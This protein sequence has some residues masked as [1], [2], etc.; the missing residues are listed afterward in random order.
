MLILIPTLVL[1]IFNFKFLFRQIWDKKFKGDRFNWKLAHMISREC[2]SLFQNQLF[3][4]QILISFLGKFESK[5]SK[6]PVLTDNW[7]T[8]HISGMLILIPKLVCWIPNP[9]FLF[10]QIWVKKV[11]VVHFNWKLAHMI[12][13]GCWFLFQH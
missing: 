6:L 9:N 5:K 3:E 7:H 4:F 8:H 2:S 11:K 1:W 13:W 10:R 12:S